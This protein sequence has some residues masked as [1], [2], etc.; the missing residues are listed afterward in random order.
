MEKAEGEEDFREGG[1]DDP[2][3]KES[4]YQIRRFGK[5]E[6]TKRGGKTGGDKL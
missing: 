2:C 4:D 5:V 3:K 1:S 6:C